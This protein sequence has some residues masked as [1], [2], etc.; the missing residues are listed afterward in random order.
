MSKHNH[1]SKP[2]IKLPKAV[3]AF[4]ASLTRS[5]ERAFVKDMAALEY[6]DLF[7]SRSRSKKSNKTENTSE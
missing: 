6:R 4:A 2:V 3:K 1:N 7:S 5:K